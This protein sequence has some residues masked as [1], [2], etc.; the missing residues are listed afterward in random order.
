MGIKIEVKRSNSGGCD[1]RDAISI[2]ISDRY[3][4]DK[5][6]SFDFVDGEPEDAN[7]SRDFSDVYHIA[8][9]IDAIAKRF[10]LDAMIV[11]EDVSW[12]KFYDC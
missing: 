12:D 7:L 3:N 4:G 2:K 10:N 6:A 1:C 11:E 9:A 5:L 8:T